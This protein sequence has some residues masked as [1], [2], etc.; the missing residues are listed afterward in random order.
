MVSPAGGPDNQPF[1]KAVG[2]M[3][4]DGLR[5]PPSM[6]PIATRD[7]LRFGALRSLS[8]FRAMTRDPTL[9]R[10]CLVDRCSAPV[11]RSRRLTQTG[12]GDGAAAAKRWSG[13]WNRLLGRRVAGLGPGLVAL[14]SA[15]LGPA[16]R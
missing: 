7:Y 10:L 14:Q 5:E 16:A 13:S 8:L 6:L 12:V 11:S 1:S 3:A 15:D 9:E 4:T 2:Q